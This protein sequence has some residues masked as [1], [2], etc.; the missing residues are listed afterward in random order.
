M[1]YSSLWYHFDNISHAWCIGAKPIWGLEYFY[2]CASVCG[3]QIL[4]FIP[5]FPCA[6]GAST[7]CMPAGASA[8]VVYWSLMQRWHH[9]SSFSRWNGRGS[10]VITACPCSRLK[11]PS[12][13]LLIFSKASM[14]VEE[15]VE[16]RL[17][18]N[19]AGG[20]AVPGELLI[21]KHSSSPLTK[22]CCCFAS[23]SEMSI[24]SCLV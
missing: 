16:P 5:L 19:K 15:K 7:V 21:L 6:C 14:L 13:Q 4:F 20:V 17:V 23:G 2:K 10:L 3:Q 11:G 9:C 12:E 22:L 1:K 24:D 18:V 8:H